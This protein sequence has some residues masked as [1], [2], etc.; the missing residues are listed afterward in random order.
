MKRNSRKSIFEFNHIDKSLSEE[1][2]ET[3]KDLYK[4][5]HKKHWCYKKSYKS[6]KFLDNIFLFLVYLLLLLALSQEG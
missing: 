5:Y 1:Q 2:R 4:H 3:I 6:Y